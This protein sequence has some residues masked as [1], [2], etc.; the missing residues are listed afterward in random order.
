MSLSENQITNEGIRHLA[1]FLPR[2][3][4]LK[5]LELV[6]CGLLDAGFKEFGIAMAE[7]KGIETLDISRNKEI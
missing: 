5:M 4:T 2:N 7:N 1:Q 3:N 6:K